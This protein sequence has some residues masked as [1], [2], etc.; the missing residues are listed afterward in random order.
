M[1]NRK[2]ALSIFGN[3]FVEPDR[4]HPAAPIDRFF[5]QLDA[6]NM[7]LNFSFET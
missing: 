2:G 4:S 5:N 7:E 3:E 1:L 6:L